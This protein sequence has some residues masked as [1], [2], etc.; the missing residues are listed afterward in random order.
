MRASDKTREPAS[1]EWAHQLMNCGCGW[2]QKEKD[3]DATQHIRIAS[4]YRENNCRL[5]RVMLKYKR[6]QMHVNHLRSRYLM[7]ETEGAQ[8]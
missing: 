3:R 7:N 6:A 4:W 1:S 5:Y 2:S 8:L